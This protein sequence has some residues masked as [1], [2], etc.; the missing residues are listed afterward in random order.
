M[1]SHALPLYALQE[2]TPK[3][4]SIFFV[5]LKLNKSS[6]AKGHIRT[7]LEKNL[8]KDVQETTLLNDHIIKMYLLFLNT[9]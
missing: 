6:T 3:T 2:A 7:Y 9:Y 5:S 4:T 8:F 1:A